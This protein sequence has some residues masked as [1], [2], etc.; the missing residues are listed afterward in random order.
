MHVN[1]FPKRMATD[2]LKEETKLLGISEKNLIT[3]AGSKR[4]ILKMG[5]DI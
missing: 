2:L 3:H 1:A 4:A 5:C